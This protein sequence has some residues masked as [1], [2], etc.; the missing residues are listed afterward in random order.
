[1]PVLAVGSRRVAFFLGGTSPEVERFDGCGVV[2]GSGEARVVSK[3]GDR[4]GS[5]AWAVADDVELEGLGT[6][7]Q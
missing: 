1:M 2:R 5:R 3:P 7:V 4:F 6:T